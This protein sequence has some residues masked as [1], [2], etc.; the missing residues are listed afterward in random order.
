VTRPLADLFGIR[1]PALDGSFWRRMARFGARG[2]AWFARFSPP[3]IGMTICAFSP[4]QRRVIRENLRRVRGPRTR[5]RDTAEVAQIF[6]T[7]ACCLSEALGGAT[8]G[9]RLPEAAIDGDEHV[10]SA[11]ADRRGV[12]FATAHTAGWEVVGPVL[13][14]RRGLPVMIAAAPEREAAARSIQDDARREQG[15]LVAHVGDDPFAGLA[16]MRHLREGG[17]VAMQIDRV[18]PGQRA[19]EVR[20]FGERERIPEGPLRLAALTGAPVLPVFTAREGYRRYRVVA[21]APIRLDRAAGEAELD[22]GAQRI[23]DALGAFVRAHPTQ[24]FHFR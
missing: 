15:L 5:L 19:R 24:W 20:L 3:L 2:P 10:R 8:A 22:A 6:A 11:L 21:S 9:G 12:I 16:L 23:A 4:R 18:P 14:E 13:R 17:I 1:L 7:Y